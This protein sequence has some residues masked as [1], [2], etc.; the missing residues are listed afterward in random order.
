MYPRQP[1]TRNLPCSRTPPESGCWL[2]PLAGHLESAWLWRIPRAWNQPRRHTDHHRSVWPRAFLA[3]LLQLACHTAK[4][5]CLLQNQRFAGTNPPLCDHL[6]TC[7]WFRLE[8]PHPSWRICFCSSDSTPPVW[9]LSSSES[10]PSQDLTKQQCGA[11]SGLASPR[12]EWFSSDWATRTFLLLYRMTSI[13]CQKCRWPV[14]CR[15]KIVDCECCGTSCQHWLRSSST[16]GLLWLHRHSCFPPTRARN[17]DWEQRESIPSSWASSWCHHWWCQRQTQWTPFCSEWPTRGSDHLQTLPSAATARTCP[18]A[19]NGASCWYWGSKHQ[20]QS[21]LWNG[22]LCEYSISGRFWQMRVSFE[23][24]LQWH[25]RGCCKHV[26]WG[27]LFPW[28]CQGRKPWWSSLYTTPSRQR[29][30]RDKRQEWTRLL[31]D[32]TISSGTPALHQIQST[33]TGCCRRLQPL[34][35]YLAGTWLRG[36]SSQTLQTRLCSASW[37]PLWLSLWQINGSAWHWPGQAS[38]RERCTILWPPDC[39]DYFP[40]TAQ[41]GTP[42][43]NQTRERLDQSDYP[44]DQCWWLWLDNQH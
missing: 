8:R 36:R 12:T 20:Y 26:H 28:A 19:N 10:H 1:S 22:T 24:K 32:R 35:C 37:C 18:R 17:R 38:D 31:H 7:Q 2:Q 4:W 25:Q 13:C 30:G 23:R 43:D 16:D 27:L 42:S 6:W 11:Y 14:C 39:T 40:R 3:R 34:T 5:F 9:H 41:M 29:S 15:R 44:T 33:C 21:T